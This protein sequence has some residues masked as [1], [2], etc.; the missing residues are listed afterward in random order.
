MAEQ[1][2]RGMRIANYTRKV[3]EVRLNKSDICLAMLHV[4]GAT[5]NPRRD[6][7]DIPTMMRMD[8]TVP[9]FADGAISVEAAT[10]WSVDRG[11]VLVAVGDGALPDMIY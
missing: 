3:V 4:P 2:L 1:I 6:S 9:M 5:P 8:F 10:T 7:P 11:W